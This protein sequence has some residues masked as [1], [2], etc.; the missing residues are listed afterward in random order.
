MEGALSAK[1]DGA[2]VENE[3]GRDDFCSNKLSLV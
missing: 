1:L 3:Q 2:G